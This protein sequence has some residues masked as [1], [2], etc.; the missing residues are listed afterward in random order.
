MM[1]LVT[2][3][4]KQSLN[5]KLLGTQWYPFTLLIFGLSLLKQNSRK[6]GT[7]IMKG[8]LGNLDLRRPRVAGFACISPEPQTDSMSR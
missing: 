5:L 1:R 7:L 4:P 2:K 8:L 6:K 3:C